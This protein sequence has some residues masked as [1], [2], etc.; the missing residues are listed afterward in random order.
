MFDISLQKEFNFTQYLEKMLPPAVDAKSVDLEDK[1]RLEFYKLEQTFKGDISLNP[2]VETFTLENPKTLKTSGKGVD[3]DEL[4]E[5]IIGKI[6]ERFQG[7]F[8]DSDRVIV[9]TIY[10][11]CVKD[12]K[13]L[14]MQAKKNDEEVFNQSIFPEIFKQVA[15]DC[16]MEQMKAFSKLFEDKAFYESVMES[17]AKE[18]YKDLRNI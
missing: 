5:N 18:A 11:K 7:I 10:N 15:Q 14:K 12:N 17:I 13:K 2:T 8:T 6:N 16:Y 3:E 9:E 1:L 4:L